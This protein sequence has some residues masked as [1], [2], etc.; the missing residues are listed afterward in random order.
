M[1]ASFASP[2]RSRAASTIAA[3]LAFILVA[4]PSLPAGAPAVLPVGVVTPP[5]RVAVVELPIAHTVKRLRLVSSDPRPKERSAEQSVIQSKLRQAEDDAKESMIEALEW[6]GEF[7]V[8]KNEAA[9]SLAKALDLANDDRPIPLDRLD[10][11]RQKT[12]V[13]AILRFRITDYGRTPRKV[14]KWIYAGTFAWIAGVITVAALNSNTRPYIGAYIGTEVVQEGA[15]LY[16]GTSFFGHEYKP[17]RIEAELIDTRTGRNLWEDAKTRTAS[18]KFL[19]PY[20]KPQRTK[21]LELG[22]SSDRAI[23]DLAR[24]LAKRLLGDKSLWLKV[25]SESD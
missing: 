8:E 7:S 19:A 12:G 13:D 4:V 14:L 21:E 9:Q 23:V 3:A 18:R 16:L 25:P 22:V 11:F 24:S 20:P 10:Q 15:E 5:M 17:V 1:T 6:K 2:L